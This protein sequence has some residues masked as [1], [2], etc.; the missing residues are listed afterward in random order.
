[1]QQ[2]RRGSRIVDQYCFWLIGG[3]GTQEDRRVA[4]FGRDLRGELIRA[5]HIFAV[6]TSTKPR[7]HARRVPRRFR[8]VD[9]LSS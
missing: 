8:I 7:M 1:M 2:S 5:R 9:T 6:G 4:A 3:P